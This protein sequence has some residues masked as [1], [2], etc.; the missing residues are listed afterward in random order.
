MNRA[1][2]NSSSIRALGYDPETHLLEIEFHS[3]SVYCYE[4]VP[5]QLVLNLLQAESPGGYFN[6]IF[7]PCQF[8]YRQLL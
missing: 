1:L 5:E 8:P 4:Q 3:G 2:I 7:K 6:R